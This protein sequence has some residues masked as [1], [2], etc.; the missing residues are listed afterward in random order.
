MLAY[1]PYMDPMGYIYIYFILLVNIYIYNYNIYIY[2]NVLG[3]FKISF[4]ERCLMPYLVPPHL[5]PLA[6]G[7]HPSLSSVPHLCPGDQAIG[8]SIVW[9]GD[10]Y[11]GWYGFVWKCRVPHFPMVLL[12]I[13]P[14]KWLFRW[15]Y[16]LFSDIP[17]W[18]L[19]WLDMISMDG[20]TSS[21][22]I[23]YPYQEPCHSQL[24]CT[25]LPS[26]T[27]LAVRWRCFVARLALAMAL[28]STT[29]Q[30]PSRI[31]DPWWLSGKAMIKTQRY[32]GYKMLQDV[33]PMFCFRSTS[34]FVHFCWV[35]VI[36]TQTH[37]QSMKNGKSFSLRS[38]G[39]I[40][41][42]QSVIHAPLSL[43]LMC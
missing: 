3:C 23:K 21:H 28:F 12:I 38:G 17:I 31:G 30:G 1:I 26:C 8:W 35:S 42:Y 14:T 7:K 15:G 40:H 24:C 13:I 33:T 32:S 4:V 29:D 22:I 34:I 27:T 16:T 18:W 36:H 43:Y 6:F 10:W 2:I 25:L 11:G 20:H 5:R 39:A 9:Y 37:K 41:F 19:I